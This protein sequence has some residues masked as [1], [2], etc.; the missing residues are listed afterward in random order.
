MGAPLQVE[1]L[2]ERGKERALKPPR[3]YQ[4]GGNH[5]SHGL[6]SRQSLFVIEFQKDQNATQAAIRAGYSAKTATQAGSENLRRVH[7]ARE[8][9]IARRRMEK[10]IEASGEITKERIIAG[11]SEIAFAATTHER[12][13]LKAFELL[14]RTCGAY[15]DRTEIVGGRDMS[16][17]EDAE[18]DRLA[19]SYSDANDTS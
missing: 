18:I 9:E 14:G 1:R 6:T 12:D 15:T 3:A 16:G 5:K 7:V 17:I 11:I 10:K 13:K 4:R 2:I 8:I 19:A